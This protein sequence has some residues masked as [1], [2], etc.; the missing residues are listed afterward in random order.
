MASSEYK[1]VVTVRD[2]GRGSLSPSPQTRRTK[3]EGGYSNNVSRSACSTA[4]MSVR[5][6]GSAKKQSPPTV[7]AY[8]GNGLKVSNLVELS[9]KLKI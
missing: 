2:S 6:N 5:I 8:D 7:G 3:E 9:E 1:R 4:L